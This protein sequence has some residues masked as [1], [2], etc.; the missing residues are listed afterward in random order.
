MKGKYSFS[1]FKESSETERDY[2]LKGSSWSVISSRL[3]ADKKKSKG[4]LAVVFPWLLIGGFLISNLLLVNNQKE[5]KEKIEGLT[6]EFSTK[7]NV[8]VHSDTVYI[9]KTIV[10]TVYLPAPV[11]LLGAKKVNYVNTSKG[12]NVFWSKVQKDN[13]SKS[14]SVN[15]VT[16]TGG[17]ISNVSNLN[18]YTAPIT[19]GLNSIN[20]EIIKGDEYLD[21]AIE[22]ISTRDL[23]M[24]MSGEDKVREVEVEAETEVRAAIETAQGTKM[25]MDSVVGVDTIK[26]TNF[27]IAKQDSADTEGEKQDKVKIPLHYGL[28]LLVG[29]TIPKNN[30]LEV[31]IGSLLGLEFSMGKQ[32]FDFFGRL[33]YRSVEITSESFNATYGLPYQSVPSEDYSLNMAS[34][35]L[36]SV[37]LMIGGRF[38]ILQNKRIKP[39]VELGYGVNRVLPYRAIYSFTDGT[40]DQFVIVVKDIEATP[41][42]F[43]NIYFGLGLNTILKGPW[44]LSL[45]GEYHGNSS[46]GLLKNSNFIGVRCGLSYSF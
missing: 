6:Y 32:W 27:N 41:F 33:N 42:N 28:K 18:S 7:N 44:S 14:K 11:V 5:L 39:Y 17:G 40:D 2:D 1:A 25:E 23:A 37:S 16:S 21:L 31:S 19:N 20:K 10:D 12:V 30:E 34:A 38:F 3:D 26:V 29:A 13:K 4:R 46:P 24:G 8:V 36:G 22:K 15:S 43:K 35:S 9:Q 45:S